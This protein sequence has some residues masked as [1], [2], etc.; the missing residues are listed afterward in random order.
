MPKVKGKISR[1]TFQAIKPPNLSVQNWKAIEEEY[2]RSIPVNTRAEITG[3]TVRFLQL[4]AAQKNAPLKDDALERISRLRKRAQSFLDAINEPPVGDELR[5]YVDEN[6]ALTYSLFDFD[7]PLSTRSYVL[8]LGLELKRFVRVCDEDRELLTQYDFWPSG[9]AWQ[10]WI[11]EL[12]KILENQRLPTG[13]RKDGQNP[14]QFANFVWSLH[15]FLPREYIRA[16]HSKGAL[17]TAISKSRN[18][19]K[20]LVRR[21][22]NAGRNTKRSQR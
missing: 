4:A 16:A 19:S 11:R 8:G 18:E 10:I 13:V 14:S 17:A 12:T 2:G 15:S 21:T 22:R 3:A 6:L 5:H 7:N 1:I 9:R 20:P